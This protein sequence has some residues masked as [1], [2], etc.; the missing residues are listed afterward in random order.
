ME[1]AEFGIFEIVVTHED[2]ILASIYDLVFALKVV[3]ESTFKMLRTRTRTSVVS[4]FY[5]IVL[6]IIDLLKLISQYYCKIMIQNN[7]IYQHSGLWKD[8]DI[9]LTFKDVKDDLKGEIMCQTQRVW[10]K[11][12]VG[13]LTRAKRFD[14]VKLLSQL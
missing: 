3:S 4:H 8:F 13:L 9:K 6:R 11:S 2:Y 7:C 12:L 10:Y 14:P 5:F 1:L